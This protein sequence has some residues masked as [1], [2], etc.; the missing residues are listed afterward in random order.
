MRD[1]GKPVLGMILPGAGQGVAEAEAMYP[2]DVRFISESV[3]LQSLNREGYDA[4]VEGVAPAARR[5]AGRGADAVMLMGT[6]LSFYKGPAFN[7]RLRE[8]LAAES[9]LPALTMS[10]AIVAALRGLSAVRIAA[11][12]AYGDEVNQQLCEYL[13]VEGFAVVAV[14]GLEITS[15]CDGALDRVTSTNLMDLGQATA[16]A[17]SDADALLVSCGGLRTLD[18]LQPLEDAT[19]LPVVSSFP[20]ALW[21]GMALLGL[22]RALPGYGVLLGRE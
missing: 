15:I 14:R 9:G 6:S 7:A 22:P 21:A 10:D 20:H 4:V 19:G 2:R 1:G 16:A 5:L 13:T 3:G 8:Q 11:A 17:A 18:T 12:T